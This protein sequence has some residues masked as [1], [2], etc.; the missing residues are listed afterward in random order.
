MLPKLFNNEDFLR[1]LQNRFRTEDV[2]L[3]RNDWSGF[4]ENVEGFLGDHFL[5]S[6]TYKIAQKEGNE[7]FFI[8]TLPRKSEYQ[9]RIASELRVSE[10]EKFLYDFLLP[11]L[12]KY[13]YP[14]DFA[15]KCYYINAETFVL[16]NMKVKDFA[17]MERGKF[18]DLDHCKAALKALALYHAGSVVYEEA[19]SKELGRTYKIL[20]ENPKALQDA[21]FSSDPESFGNN[22]L[23]LSK[24]CIKILLP[25]LDKPKEWQDMLLEKIASFDPTKAL[26][27]ELPTRKTCTHGDLWSNNLLFRYSKENQ[28]NCC[29]L[30]FQMIRYHHPAYDVL[31]CIYCN[32]TRAFRKEHLSQLLEFYHQNFRQILEKH[33]LDCEIPL[34]DFLATGRVLEP[35]AAYQAFAFRT[36]VS[37]PP[38]VAGQILGSGSESLEAFLQEERPRIL[39]EICK[40]RK[41]LSRVFLEYLQDFQE[42]L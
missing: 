12:E 10:K 28:I 15:P 6:L 21:Y 18:F 11:E 8:K 38:E 20:E 13:D 3:L 27:Q 40:A 31:L 19:R 34:E 9:N 37:L 7:S 22:F 36:I 25:M 24:D 1:I 35:V 14:T 29:L 32:T 33:G 4:S 17:V 39:Y 26:H 42:L 5:L 30:D 2:E 41:E 23:E 16:E